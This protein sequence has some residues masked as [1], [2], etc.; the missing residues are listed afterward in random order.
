M[1]CCSKLN[2]FNFDIISKENNSEFKIVGSSEMLAINDS[3]DFYSPSLQLR[4][5]EDFVSLIKKT[6][7]EVTNWIKNMKVDLNSK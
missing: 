5:Y 3:E 4:N 6:K 1:N 7:S 2:E